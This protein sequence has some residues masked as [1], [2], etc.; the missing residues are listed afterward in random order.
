MNSKIRP[1]RD[2]ITNGFSGLSFFLLNKKPRNH[3][4]AGQYLCKS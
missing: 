1:A 4:A 3:Q 2:T